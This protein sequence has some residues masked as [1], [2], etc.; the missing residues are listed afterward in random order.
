SLTNMAYPRDIVLLVLRSWTVGALILSQ[1]F[2]LKGQVAVYTSD[3]RGGYDE[4][5]T[6]K[7]GFVD[8]AFMAMFRNFAVSE[9]QNHKLARL[10]VGATAQDLVSAENALVLDIDSKGVADLM[11]S[12]GSLR[13]NYGL[14]QSCI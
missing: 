13:I 11:K 9:C 1:P 6:I 2:L 7:D 12:S 5:R 3:S 10:T 4:G 8:S 14:V